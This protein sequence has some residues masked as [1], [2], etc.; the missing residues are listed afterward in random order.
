MAKD[1]KIRMPSGQGG[2]TRYFDEF[3]SKIEFSPGAVII[4]CVI[5]MVIII[6]LHVWS[7]LI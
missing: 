3:K 4:F 7:P 1:N 6:V 5:I 2:L